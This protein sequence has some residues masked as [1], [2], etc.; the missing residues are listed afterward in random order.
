MT[1]PTAE[2]RLNAADAAETPA[3]DPTRLTHEDHDLRLEYQ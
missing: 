2:G 3:A 1:N